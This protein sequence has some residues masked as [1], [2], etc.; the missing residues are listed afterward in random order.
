[1]LAYYVSFGPHGPR[2]P[3]T[4]PGSN[5]TVFL[6]VVGIL[7]TSGVVFELIRSRGK[8]SIHVSLYY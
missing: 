4:A 5:F 8:Y 1:M 6:G 3:A 7:A 2:T